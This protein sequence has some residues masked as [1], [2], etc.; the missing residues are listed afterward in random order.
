MGPPSVRSFEQT[1]SQSSLPSAERIGYQSSLPPAAYAERSS[2][3]Q[4]YNPR[5][6]EQLRSKSPLT[7][8]EARVLANQGKVIIFDTRQ[9]TYHNVGKILPDGKPRTDAQFAKDHNIEAGNL[10][11]F[12]QGD[13]PSMGGFVFPQW[14]SSREAKNEKH[15]PLVFKDKDEKEI[16]QNDMTNSEFAR[17]LGVK[18]HEVSNARVRGGNLPQ[19]KYGRLEN[20]TDGAKQLRKT[21]YGYSAARSSGTTL[22]RNFAEE[23]WKFKMN[24]KENRTPN[25]A[26]Q[27]VN[28]HR[29]ERE[30]KEI[31]LEALQR[32][33]ERWD[34]ANRDEKAYVS[35]DEENS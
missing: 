13:K 18:D 7:E 1:P 6:L 27:T 30:K 16:L 28:K 2:S 14:T 22:L 10:S 32:K 15:P 9:N 4:D 3:Q 11:H 24:W 21:N 34:A 19:T 17:H 33:R 35:S 8:D 25:K 31:N 12:L 5:Q 29:T 23:H 20:I 26:L